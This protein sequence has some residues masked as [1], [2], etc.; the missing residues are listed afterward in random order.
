MK[1]RMNFARFKA[2]P[3]LLYLPE[4]QLRNAVIAAPIRPPLNVSV[5][6][7]LSGDFYGSCLDFYFSVI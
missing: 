1:D 6:V 4:F 5:W 2:L 7:A 3:I